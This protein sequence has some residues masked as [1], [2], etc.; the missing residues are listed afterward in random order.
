M[1]V[2]HIRVPNVAGPREGRRPG[3]Y[4][5]ACRCLEALLQWR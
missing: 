3:V 4:A 5:A 2:S 1:T